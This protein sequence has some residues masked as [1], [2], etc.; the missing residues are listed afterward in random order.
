LRPLAPE[1]TIL[2]EPYIIR[3]RWD[4]LVRYLRGEMP[5][6]SYKPRVTPFSSG[7][8]GRDLSPW[9]EGR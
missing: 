1:L 4:Y 5:P 7:T 9:L 3:R 8:G 2:D 6:M